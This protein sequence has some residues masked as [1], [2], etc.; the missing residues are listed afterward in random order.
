MDS[1]ET[2]EQQIEAFRRWWKANGG[3][4]I[5]G[6]VIGLAIVLGWQYWSRYRAAQAE[7][8]SLQFDALEQAVAEASPAHIRDH[9]QAL[10]ERFSGSFYAVL[11]ALDL[12]KLAAEEGNAETAIGH[13]KWALDHASEAAVKNVVRL[14]LA[15]TLMGAGQLSQAEAELNE[16]KAE[17]FEAQIQE[18]RGDLYVARHEPV[19]ARVAYQAALAAN[20]SN[21]GLLQMKLDDLS[22]LSETVVK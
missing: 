8:A 7:Q 18:L 16:V 3:A 22:F 1:Y 2:E 15:R 10:V 13:L 19:Q 12:A 20:P 14:R 17:N 11:A 9:G 4:V 5:A 6:V 21:A